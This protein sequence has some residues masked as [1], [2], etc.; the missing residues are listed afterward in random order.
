[1]GAVVMCSH[2]HLYRNQGVGCVPSYVSM[3]G[4]LVCVSWCARGLSAL[5]VSGSQKAGAMWAGGVSS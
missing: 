1:V 4:V 3:C 2:V 5:S